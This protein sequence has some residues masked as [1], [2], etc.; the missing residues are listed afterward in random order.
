MN[1]LKFLDLYK[2][3]PIIFLII[4]L[5]ISYEQMVTLIFLIYTKNNT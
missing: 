4:L 3:N 5:F 2:N 1:N